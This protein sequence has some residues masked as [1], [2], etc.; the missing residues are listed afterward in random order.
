M[1]RLL[2]TFVVILVVLAVGF[3]GLDRALAAYAEG[4]IS[5]QTSAEIA[6]Q[7]MRSGTPTVDVGS[8][9][10]ATQVVAGEYKRIEIDIPDLQGQGVKLPMLT[11]VA[12]D[13]KAPLEALRSGTGSITAGKVT[14]T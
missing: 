3:F 11:L 4:K 9:P 8:F 10:F 2:I 13:V 1:R 6:K 12:T 5:D 14:G 7:G